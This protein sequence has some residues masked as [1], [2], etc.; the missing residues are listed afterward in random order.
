MNKRFGVWATVCGIFFIFGG[1]SA[2]AAMYYEVYHG[3]G[4]GGPLGASTLTMSNNNI[5]V[6]G[7]IVKGPGNFTDNVVFYIDTV[8]GGFA[9]TSGFSDHNNF[10]ETAVSGY[11]T[12]KSTT[13]FAP[14]FEADYA[15]VLSVAHNSSALYKLTNG[16]SGPDLVLLRGTAPG[17]L[18][19]SVNNPNDAFFTFRF[20]WTNIALPNRS[21][22][23]FK[24]E[25]T[26]V[27]DSGAPGLLESY[28]RLIS[29]PGSGAVT[30]TNYDTYGVQPVPENTN[31][32][33]A[34]FGGII[35]TVT[36]VARLRQRYRRPPS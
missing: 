5:T 25:T 31:V 2:F 6:Y 21:T 19:D 9:D 30:F 33:L 7:K 10:L 14:G 32:A 1:S 16:A 36:C 4:V 17:S 26:Y 24:F 3:N 18:L 13:Y 28:E 35:C 34:V 15:I 12:S 11:G 23:F 20:D 27:N 8:P 22:N 29:G